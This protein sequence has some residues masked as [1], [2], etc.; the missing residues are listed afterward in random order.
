M[1]PRG[2][3]EAGNA[4]LDFPRKRETDMILDEKLAAGDVIVL[5]GATGTEIARK[6]GA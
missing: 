2:A 6:G 4:S 3:F 1:A 5:D